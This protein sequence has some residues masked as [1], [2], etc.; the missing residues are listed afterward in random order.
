MAINAP[1]S[2]K[3]TETLQKL[4]DR[5][6]PKK[7][8]KNHDE[9]DEGRAGDPQGEL[10]EHAADTRRTPAKKKSKKAAPKKKSDTIAEFAKSLIKT[11]LVAAETNMMVSVELDP[12]LALT[13]AAILQVSARR[14]AV[15]AKMDAAMAKEPVA[16]APVADGHCHNG[17]QCLHPTSCICL[18][19][20]RGSRG[21]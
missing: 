4:L 9:D 10:E 16:K 3:D 1:F 14:A 20:P 17:L 21:R 18:C 11:A 13:V 6:R 15:K 2:K 5:P 7:K 19:C 8:G 12:G